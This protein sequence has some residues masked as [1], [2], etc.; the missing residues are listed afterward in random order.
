M[1]RIVV[2]ASVAIKWFLPEQHSLQ[3][4][5]LLEGGR[6]LVA[7]DLIWAEIGNVLWKRWRQGELADENARTILRD[8]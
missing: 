6:E 7:P 8:L 2:D 5:R 1:T 4:L 3:A